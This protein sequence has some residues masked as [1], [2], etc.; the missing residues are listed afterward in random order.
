MKNISAVMLCLLVFITALLS[1]YWYPEYSY[2]QLR[3][4]AAVH[5]IATK[6]YKDPSLFTVERVSWLKTDGIG[7]NKDKISIFGYRT[8][9]SD[10]KIPV[11]YICDID[12][13]ISVVE[14]RED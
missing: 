10:V 5:I 12:N 4:D 8:I 11:K 2:R 14:C 13:R 3:E 7:G 9:A 6:L 1:V